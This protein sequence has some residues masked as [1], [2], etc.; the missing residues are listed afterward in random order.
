MTPVH[1][2]RQLM[3]GS[4]LDDLGASEVNEVEVSNGFKPFLNFFIHILFLGWII[5]RDKIN[6]MK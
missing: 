4:L 3:L 1:G 5:K 6:I 2:D